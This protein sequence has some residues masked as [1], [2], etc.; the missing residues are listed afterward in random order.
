LVINVSA[1]SFTV[2]GRCAGCAVRH[3]TALDYLTHLPG[4][5]DSD[6]TGGE[7]RTPG[8]TVRKLSTVDR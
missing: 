7:S 6:V 8:G 3:S 2:D 5:A 1:G 4:L